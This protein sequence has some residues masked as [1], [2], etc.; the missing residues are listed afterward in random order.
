VEFAIVAMLFF[1]LVFGIIEFARALYMFNTMAEVT[2]I[3]AREAANISF[4][5]TDALDAARKRAV[6]DEVNGK[7]P[8]GNPITYKNIRIEYL[9]L[10]QKSLALQLI[11]SGSMPS[12]P[13]R[14]KV[15]CM[16]NPNDPSCIRAVQARIC[17]ETTAAGTCTPVPYQTLTS[18]VNLPFTLP[19]ALTI[20]TAETLGYQAGDA[21]GP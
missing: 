16:T 5:N 11:P 4:I 7:L 18:V 21:P 9:Y 19:T 1:T 10:G 2:R 14:N 17:Q 20:A 8:L 15:V 13:A 12:S 6:M 3:A